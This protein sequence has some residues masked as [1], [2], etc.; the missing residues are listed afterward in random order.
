MARYGGD[1][2]TIYCRSAGVAWRHAIVQK[3]DTHA[4]VGPIKDLARDLAR[5]GVRSLHVRVDGTG[6]FGSGVI[7]NLKDDA[8][9]LGLFED[10]RVV[11]VQFGASASDGAA[12]DNLVTEMYAETGETLRGIRVERPPEQLDA[13]L[14]ERRYKFVNASGLTVKRLQEK[15]VF[16]REHGNRS[17]DD[18]DGFVL[19]CSP[20]HVFK[21]PVVAP[22]G[23]PIAAHLLMSG[24]RRK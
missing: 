23:N 24:V 16:R 20:D 17:P 13:D 5:R 1:A 6:G 8:E 9:M 4:Y 3:E 21:P 12:Y 7:D 14:T 10:F 18:G 2:G 11:E 15:E 19:A 22:A